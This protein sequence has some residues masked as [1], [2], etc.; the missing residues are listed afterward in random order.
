[1]RSIFRLPKAEKRGE[2]KELFELRNLLR[3]SRDKNQ[4]LIRGLCASSYLGDGSAVCRVL[5]RYKMFL[6]T[7]DVGLSPHLMLDG[8]WEMWLTEALA[9]TIK[10]GMLVVDVGANLGYF[11]LLM[12]EL[13]GPGGAVHAFEPNPKIADRLTK[14]V[15]ING[16]YGRVT[17][18]RDPLG[19][20]DGADV[21]LAV[22]EGEPKN[23]HILWNSNAT[24]AIHLTMRRFDSFPELLGADVIKIDAEAAEL[25]I[26]HGMSGLLQRRDKPLIIFL[27]FASARYQDPGAFLDEITAAGFDLAEVD[28]KKGILPKSRAE[29]LAASP[30]MDQML[31]LE[32]QP[33][34]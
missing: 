22:P 33:K 1:M 5:G 25:D 13:V 11:T 19:S 26:W 31:R 6:D 29:I 30:T 17:V 14:S 24:D 12:A 15:D 7:K 2:G 3:P 23:A 27:E 28:L 9:Q 32:R 34:G 20:H 4:A 8:Y 16:F 18:H 10:P 21:V